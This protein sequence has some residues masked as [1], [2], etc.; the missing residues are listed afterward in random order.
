MNLDQYKEKRAALILEAEAFLKDGKI[1]EAK[2]KREEVEALDQAFDEICKE[3]ANVAALEEKTVLDFENKTVDVVNPTPA[4]KMESENNMN[5]Q[6]KYLL[7]F[8]KHLMNFAMNSEEKAVFDKVNADFMNESATQTAADHSVLVPETV[9]AGIWK[10]I[11]DAH[12]ILKALDL[13]FIP[14][15]VVIDKETVSGNDAAW[16]DESDEV[17]EGAIGFGT[18]N[19]TGCELAKDITVSWKLKKMAV[20][21]FIPYI[22]S[23]LAEKMG[24]ALANAVV[25][26]LGKPGE[27]DTFKPQPRGI[28]TALEAEAQTPQVKTYTAVNGVVYADITGL[29]ALVKSGYLSGGAFYAKNSMIWNQLANIES[30]NG[31]IMFVPDVTAGGVGRLFGIPVFEE[32]AAPADALLFANVAKGYAANVNEDV[33]MMFEDHI[34]AK[35]TDY[36][37]YSLVDGDVITTKAF[38]L[39]KKSS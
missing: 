17:A 34:K 8:G 26:G 38:A 18:I 9:K 19:L 21:E 14:G 10:E 39:L 33:S 13:T 3:A 37:A 2:G 7:A 28:V 12:P 25:N 1:A 11:A 22:T 36:M 29:M 6:E 15:D 20:Q 5:E 30:T 35:K 27:L 16:Y 4:G 32:D 24:N 23:K 31:Q